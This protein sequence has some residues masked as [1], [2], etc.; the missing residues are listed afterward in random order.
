MSDAVMEKPSQHHV[1]KGFIVALF[2]G[3]A[4]VYFTYIFTTITRGR[5]HFNILYLAEIVIA[6]VAIA[7]LNKNHKISVALFVIY[8]ALLLYNHR[9]IESFIPFWGNTHGM[10]FDFKYTDNSFIFSSRVLEFIL[11]AFTLYGLNKANK[12]ISIIAS[13]L[14]LIFES[15][16]LFSS[17]IYISSY[18]EYGMI[19]LYAAYYS[20]LLLPLIL[21]CCAV[22]PRW[23]H[24]SIKV[25]DS[26]MAV[27]LLL[28]VAGDLLEALKYNYFKYFDHIDFLYLINICWMP[29]MAIFGLNA[30]LVF[31]IRF[32]ELAKIFGWSALIIGMVFAAS[33]AQQSADESNRK[34]DTDREAYMNELR[35]NIQSWEAAGFSENFSRDAAQNM[36]NEGRIT[37]KEYEWLIRELVSRV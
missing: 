29:L 19:F 10:H 17:R 22:K 2:L 21:F 31:P 26:Y 1:K 30:V 16:W 8:F 18:S 32:K 35:D 9:P 24:G 5:F 3:L 6:I 20:E 13:S 23:I 34:S 37:Q 33:A 7:L 15:V 11:A 12:I 14:L 36:L 4:M 28:F 25:I 27:R